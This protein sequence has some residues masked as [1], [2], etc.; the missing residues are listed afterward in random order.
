MT[1]FH[2]I[3]R[4]FNTHLIKSF[5]K[6]RSLYL[7]VCSTQLLLILSWKTITDKVMQRIKLNQMIYVNSKC[8]CK[9]ILLQ[10]FKFPEM[11]AS[12]IKKL[13]LWILTPNLGQVCHSPLTLMSASCLMLLWSVLLEIALLPVLTMHG[14]VTYLSVMRF[15]NCSPS[16]VCT[17]RSLMVKEALT[18]D[19]CTLEAQ[20]FSSC[21][22]SVH[23]SIGESPRNPAP[24]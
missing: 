22:S 8:H 24:R 7:M 9:C 19:M 16:A 23:W 12:A 10:E 5:R 4:I 13:L 6:G 1:L 17:N 18:N 21:N 11:W 14:S 3:S 2:A 20:P 15:R